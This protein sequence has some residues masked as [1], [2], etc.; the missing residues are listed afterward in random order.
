MKG[1]YGP[2]QEQVAKYQEY[3]EALLLSHLISAGNYKLYCLL[4][5]CL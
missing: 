4:T 3:E 1:V 2:L 5:V